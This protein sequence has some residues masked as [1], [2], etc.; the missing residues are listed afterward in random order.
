ME[1]CPRMAA[2]CQAAGI[3][4]IPASELTAELNGTEIHQLG[5][6]L[7]IEN[8]KLQ[9]ALAKFQ[10]VR[11]RRVREMA[12]RLNQLNVP[13]QAE[14]VFALANCGAPGRPHVAR[15]LVQGGFCGSLDEAFERFLNVGK[16]AWAPKFQ[17][18]AVHAIALI[19]QAVALAAMPHPHLTPA[20]ETIPEVALPAMNALQ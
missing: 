6:F 17:I 18:S 1:G 15:A 20:D 13:L 9:A 19:H 2:A 7:D 4:F 14:A 5:Y 11:R 10:E 8:Q 3:E 16:P 12:A